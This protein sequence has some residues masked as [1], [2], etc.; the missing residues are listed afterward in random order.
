MVRWARLAF[1]LV[2]GLSL[3]CAWAQ[4]CWFT[5]LPQLA[6][7]VKMASVLWQGRH[8]L[9]LGCSWLAAIIQALDIC[10]PRRRMEAEIMSTWQD[11]SMLSVRWMVWLPF[12][13]AVLE[14]GVPPVCCTAVV[15]YMSS[16]SCSTSGGSYRR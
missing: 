16:A 12:S 1:D 4:W 8:Y 5:A 9:Y 14:S 6:L 3:C 10:D 13:T 7:T 2:S 15:T 11:P